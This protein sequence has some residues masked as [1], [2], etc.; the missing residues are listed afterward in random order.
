MTEE[1]SQYERLKDKED[2]VEYTESY[3]ILNI[4]NDKEEEEYQDTEDDLAK[5]YYNITKNDEML[6]N[7]KS[8]IQFPSLNI[9]NTSTKSIDIEDDV[10]QIM[11]KCSLINKED[12]ENFK[13][14]KKVKK[15][16][17]WIFWKMINIKKI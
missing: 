13:E 14:E 11:E 2:N 6:Y 1:V 12:K 10:T 9:T 15:M 4:H 16:K 5:H 17:K 3:D 8:Y 7:A